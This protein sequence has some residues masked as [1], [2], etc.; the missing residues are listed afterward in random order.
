LLAGIIAAKRGTFRSLAHI[1]RRM[2]EFDGKPDGTPEW[3]GMLA[4]VG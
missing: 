1:S 4:Q 3:R 2:K